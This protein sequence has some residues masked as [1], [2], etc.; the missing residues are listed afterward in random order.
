MGDVR[1][2]LKYWQHIAINMVGSQNKPFAVV[3]NP[4]NNEYF[5]RSLESAKV[6]KNEIVWSSDQPEIKAEPVPLDIPSGLL[7][8]YLITG[9]GVHCVVG[10]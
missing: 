4:I 10:M 7:I 1:F 2:D 6:F 8:T 3:R 5:V 9:G